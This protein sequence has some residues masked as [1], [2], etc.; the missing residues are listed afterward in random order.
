MGGQM[1]GG[2]GKYTE[3]TAQRLLL[4]FDAYGGPTAC[5]PQCRRANAATVEHELFSGAHPSRSPERRTG[6]VQPIESIYG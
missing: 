5:C 2:V 4:V 3:R 6:A 1:A